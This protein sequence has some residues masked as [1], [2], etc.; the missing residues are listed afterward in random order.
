MEVLPPTNLEIRSWRVDG[1]RDRPCS[2]V[3]IIASTAD[4]VHVFE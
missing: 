1:G 2:F 3:Q 4:L